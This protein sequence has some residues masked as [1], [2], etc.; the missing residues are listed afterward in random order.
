[1]EGVEGLKVYPWSQVGSMRFG[2]S[3]PRLVWGEKSGLRVGVC[4]SGG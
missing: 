3:N 2:A 4:R 1:M